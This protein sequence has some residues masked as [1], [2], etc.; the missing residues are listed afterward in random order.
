M[1]NAPGAEDGLDFFV[2]PSKVPGGVLPGGR[3]PWH[4]VDGCTPSDPYWSK[5]PARRWEFVVGTP[6]DGVP[7]LPVSLATQS[8]M[9]TMAMEH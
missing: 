4:H 5:T 9:T 7:M 3:P 6:Y 1:D 2:P 8:T